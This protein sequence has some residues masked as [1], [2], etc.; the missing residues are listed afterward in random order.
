[1]PRVEDV[2]DVLQQ[3]FLVM[4]QKFDENCPE[5]SFYTGPRESPIGSAQGPRPW[6]SRPGGAGSEILE[7]IA[8]E[9]DEEP[10]FSANL[11]ALLED[12]LGK[13]AP[14]DRS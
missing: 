9:E 6:P 14:D 2:E 7:K 12:C 11:K 13:L 1:M 8:E 4:W 3:A 10:E 5:P